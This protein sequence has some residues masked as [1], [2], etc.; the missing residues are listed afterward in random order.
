MNQIAQIRRIDADIKTLHGLIDEADRAKR[1]AK[2]AYES[3]R[4]KLAGFPKPIPD[5]RKGEYAAIEEA[6]KKLHAAMNE[7]TAS[8]DGFRRQSKDLEAQRNALLSDWRVRMDVAIQERSELIESIDKEAVRAGDLRKSM[9]NIDADLKKHGADLSKALHDKEAAVSREEMS[10]AKEAIEK[11]QANIADLEGIK[12]NIHNRIAE[13]D[14]NADDAKRHLSRLEVAIWQ[15]RLD[16]LVDELRD[17]N[18]DLLISIMAASEKANVDP[19]YKLKLLVDTMPGADILA[20][21][22]SRL[23]AELGLI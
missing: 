1:R 23:S 19:R 3:E 8:C 18:E 21:A 9:V 16:G 4:N 7:A 6:V 22:L 2:E 15:A 20:T 5:Y 11:A 13:I 17:Q 10:S 12:T 14:R